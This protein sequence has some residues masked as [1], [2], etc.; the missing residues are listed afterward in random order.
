MVVCSV[1]EPMK[2]ASFAFAALLALAAPAA[3]AQQPPATPPATPAAEDQPGLKIRGLSFLVDDPTAIFAHDPAAT[4]AG[5]GVKF[6]IKSYLN[7]EYSTVPATGDTIVFT[8]SAEVA[9][10]KDPA[11]IVARAKMPANFKKGIFIFLP[12]T[13]KAGDPTYR[14]M[15]ID[16]AV[17][18]FPRGSVKVINIS[19]TPVKITLEKEEY[20]FKPGETKLIENPPVDADNSSAMTAFQF[21]DNQWQ[22]FAAGVWPHPGQKRV[23]EL[24]FE[25]PASKRTELQGIRDVAVRDN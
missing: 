16:D 21:K 9:S 19:P 18:V 25:N 2:P 7:H 17:R 5:P 24:I 23:I 14:V 3:F 13:G 20:T 4:K 22:R 12:G 8:K 11:S 10:V 6:D 1:F 15:A